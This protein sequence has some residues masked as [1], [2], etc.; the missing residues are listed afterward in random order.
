MSDR[1]S[2]LAALKTILEEISEVEESVVRTYLG[3]DFDITQYAISDLP[4]I[5]ISE[6]AEDTFEEMTSQR[7]MMSLTAKLMV[8]FVDWAIDPDATKYEDLVKKIRNKIG[9]NFTLNDTATECRVADIS[10]I[11]GT[12][13]VFNFVIGLEVR[14]YLNEKNV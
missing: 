12:L 7:S 3:T 10:T 1:R 4:L 11:L 9:A 2:V 8:Y 14:Y 5:V 13:P 6:P